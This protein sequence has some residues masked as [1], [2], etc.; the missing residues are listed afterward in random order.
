MFNFDESNVP[1]VKL[2]DSWTLED[3]SKYEVYV[4]G[5]WDFEYFE[6]EEVDFISNARDAVYAWI[7]WL[8]WLE[9]NKNELR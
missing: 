6:D 5:G 7:A 4:A 3:G 2:E 1:E 9:N 8:N